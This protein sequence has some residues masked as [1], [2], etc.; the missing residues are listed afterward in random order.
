MSATRRVTAN[1]ATFSAPLPTIADAVRAAG[2]DGIEIWKDDID[3]SAGG[4]S[5]VSAL[6]KRASLALST[7]QLLRDFEGSG[8]RRRDVQAEAERLMEI[9]MVVGA[10][11]LLVCANTR[12]DSS[13]DPRDQVRDLRALAQMAA[14]RH[15]KIAFE[16]LA[17][18]RWL[19]TY[20]KAWECVK[21]VDHPALGLTVDMFHLFSRGTPIEFLEQIPIEKFF[22]VQLCNA[23]PMDLPIIA[24]ARHHRLF[25]AEGSWPVAAVA[26]RLE[27][28][29]FEGFYS[30]EVFN[31][32]YR[33][34]DTFGVARAAWESFGKLFGAESES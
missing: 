20:E 12:A 1:T 33:R 25:P 7:F 4:A 32:E 10:D 2:F 23:R 17:W 30:V 14:A 8:A 9:M 22:G 21:A 15:L 19:D 6:L 11:T 18:S 13:G 31:D 29:G 28:R 26:Q 3:R 16:P 27:A 5:E 24:I 34:Q